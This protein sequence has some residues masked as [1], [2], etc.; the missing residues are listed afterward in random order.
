MAI[1]SR[2]KNLL[3]GSLNDAL[4]AVENPEVV[5]NQM[6]RDME[7]GIGE[8]RSNL[9]QNLVTLKLTTAKKGKMKAEIVQWEANA[10]AAVSQNRDDLAKKALAKK[11]ELQGLGKILSEEV[12]TLTTLME[13]AKVDLSQLEDRVQEARIKRDTLIT[14]HRAAQQQKKAMDVSGKFGSRAEDIIS[15]FSSFEEKIDRESAELEAAFE[16]HHQ[17]GE[18]VSLETFS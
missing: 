1:F 4:D 9:T 10:N 2:I 3:T 17:E 6:I 15:G 7:A 13:K 8:A 18:E 11:M 12:E 16:V 14:K 5:V